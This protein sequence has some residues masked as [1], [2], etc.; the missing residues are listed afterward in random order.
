MAI[1]AS[2]DCRVRWYRERHLPVV[3]QGHREDVRTHLPMDRF[4]LPRTFTDAPSAELLRQFVPVRVDRQVGERAV[5]ERQVRR[6]V[7]DLDIEHDRY[8]QPTKRV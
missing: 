7:P 5:D 8:A 2:A 4:R 6:D 1:K 3:G